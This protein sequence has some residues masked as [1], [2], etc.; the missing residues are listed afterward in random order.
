M[1]DS[2]YNLNLNDKTSVIIDHTGKSTACFA[3]K[4]NV[5]INKNII[6]EL[7]IL[8]IDLGRKD[9]RICL[10][11]DR[12]SKLHNMINLTYKNNNNIPHKHK[13]KSESYHIIEGRLLITIYDNSGKTTDMLLLDSKNNF[14]FRIGKDIFHTAV[15]D[16]NYVIFHESRSGPFTEKSDSIFMDREMFLA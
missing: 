3:V 1:T 6:E 16:T 10:H 15:S 8:S 11:N 9:L 4:E 2:I 5:I 12:E 13:Y 7:K 14:L